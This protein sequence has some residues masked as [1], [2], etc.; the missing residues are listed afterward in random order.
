M[1]RPVQNGEKLV[2]NSVVVCGL[3]RLGLPL[4]LNLEHV[5]GVHVSG[6]DVDASHV[7]AL[8]R[9]RFTSEEPG[10]AALLASSH[11]RFSADIA[12]VLGSELAVVCVRTDS[13]HS[14]AYDLRQLW[15]FVARLTE[16]LTTHHA[17][18]LRALAVTCNVNPGTCRRVAATLAPFGI[19]VYFWP[20]WVRQ[21]SIVEDQRSPPMT[22]IGTLPEYRLLEE[23]RVVLTSIDRTK[24]SPVRILELTE[25]E[26]CKLALNCFCTM[27][28]SFANMV[29][30]LLDTLGLSSTRVLEAL[31]HD[32]RIGSALL[33][34]GFGYGGPC[35]P[36]D[37]KAMSAFASQFGIE[38]PLCDAAD[39]VN[40][41]RHQH[42][43]RQAVH[44]FHAKGLTPAV[45]SLGYK[46]GVAIFTDSQ[47]LRLVA[48]LSAVGIPAQVIDDISVERAR[49]L[50]ES[51]ELLITRSDASSRDVEKKA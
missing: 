10:V 34:P 31:G 45:D 39:R 47:Q 5:G 17:P 50:P 12:S 51:R 27:K 26:L 7:E 37:N 8:A 41:R 40:E 23:V 36:R 1:A 6:Y 35:F 28:I 25:A 15:A 16:A 30:T 14:G 22:V 33:R 11:M 46:P 38:M 19:E 4:A 43:S 32:P 2:I 21:G 49:C 24:C 3:G 9:R 18:D 48:Q 20:E 42:L 13:E 29:A 44:D